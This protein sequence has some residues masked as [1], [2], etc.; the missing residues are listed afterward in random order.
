MKPT[1]WL[2]TGLTGAAPRRQWATL[3][4]LLGVLVRQLSALPF[5]D[6]ALRGVPP[7]ENQVIGVHSPSTPSRRRPQAI[8]RGRQAGHHLPDHMSTPTWRP[9]LVRQ[10][11]Q[12]ASTWRT[13]GQLRPTPE[14]VSDPIGRMIRR[15]LADQGN[16]LPTR[17][18]PTTASKGNSPHARDLLG[19]RTCSK[20]RGD[21]PTPPGRATYAAR[22]R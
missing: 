17:S 16:A 11:Y 2:N 18:S 10:P 7:Y 9:G 6:Q 20:L 15:L 13:H 5:Q 14:D 1:A 8:N 22:P 19:P 12:P 4:R 3:V 21:R